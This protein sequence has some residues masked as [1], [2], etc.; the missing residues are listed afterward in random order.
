MVATRA[1]RR[2]TAAAPTDAA[3]VAALPPLADTIALAPA[4]PLLAKQQDA[5]ECTAPPFSPVPPPPPSPRTTRR[6]RSPW[7]ASFCPA[8]L[9]LDSNHLFDLLKHQTE[10][11]N[12][13][14]VACRSSMSLPPPPSCSSRAP[15]SI[16]LLHSGSQF[17]IPHH[18]LHPSVLH[19]HLSR[20]DHHFSRHLGIPPL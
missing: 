17:H 19:N 15:S 10:R 7:G 8:R 6:R 20:H 16:I 12:L 9:L 1:A 2:R 18:L 3:P 11:F 13:A 4:A 5:G 14:L